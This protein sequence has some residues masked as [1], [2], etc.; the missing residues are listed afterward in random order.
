MKTKHT[1]TEPKNQIARNV[2][3]RSRESFGRT[4]NGKRSLE[5]KNENRIQRMEVGDN[6]VTI[7]KVGVEE[8]STEIGEEQRRSFWN[9][10]ETFSSF[11]YVFTQRKSLKIPA[12]F[13]KI[14]KSAG[15]SSGCKN[16]HENPWKYLRIFLNIP[17]PQ[18]ISS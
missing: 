9:E 3:R 6:G 2:E 16:P 11:F 18:E 7:M 1:K 4:E 12:D 13:P 10:N 14:P 5:P 15:K 8:Q 17:N